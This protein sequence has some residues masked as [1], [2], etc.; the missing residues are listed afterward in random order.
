MVLL[1]VAYAAGP[2]HFWAC[3]VFLVTGSMVFLTSSVYHFLHDGYRISPE[4]E[5]LLEDF[6]HYCIYLFIAGTYTPFLLNAVDPTWRVFLLVGIWIIALMGIVYT[7]LKPHLFAILQ[8]RAVY[9]GLF[10]VMGLLVVVRMG[11]I[12]SRLTA[13]QLRLFFG[14]NLAYLIGAVGYVIRRPVLFHGLF[15]YHELWHFMVLAGAT[16]HF[17]CI[18]SF[19]A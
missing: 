12:Y 2:A 13:D 19:Y 5:L 1:P 3:S 4:L 9:T 18:Y 6:D 10:V 11:E 15:G 8:S 14:G 7:K 16:L 17:A